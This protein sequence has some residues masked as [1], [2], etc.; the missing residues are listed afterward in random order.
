MYT[1]NSS[2]GKHM[3]GLTV[4]FIY[5]F[6]ACNAYADDSD[7]NSSLK[8]IADQSS[9]NIKKTEQF[10]PG[11]EV[12]TSTGKVVK[13][14]STEGPVKVGKAPEPFEDREKSVLPIGG[15]EIDV[16]DTRKAG[17]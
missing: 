15:V 13:V 1:I 5:F 9:A 14:W 7:S 6:I 16:D 10:I 3:K 8:E 17:F 11:E 4:F 2:K 12:V